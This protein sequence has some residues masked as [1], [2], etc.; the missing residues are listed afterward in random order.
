MIPQ[1]EE[2][3]DI[4]EDGALLR[5]SSVP[6]TLRAA[7]PDWDLVSLTGFIKSRMGKREDLVIY[8]EHSPSA[9][10]RGSKSA[11][12]AYILRR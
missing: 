10:A 3:I 2:I 6:M 4:A 1:S 5:I 11:Y 9:E 12:T 7:V 8:L